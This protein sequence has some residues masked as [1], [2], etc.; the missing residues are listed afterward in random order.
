MEAHNHARFAKALQV[1]ATAC[2]LAEALYYAR[3]EAFGVACRHWDALTPQERHYYV[4]AARDALEAVRPVS[5]SSS[6]FVLA[7]DLARQS[8][9]V[10][11]AITPTEPYT[12]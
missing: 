1:N 11:G 3:S 6:L 4:G 7:A 10:V 12:A 2:T 8:S 5:S 9:K